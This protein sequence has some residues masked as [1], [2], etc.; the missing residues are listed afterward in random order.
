LSPLTPADGEAVVYGATAKECYSNDHHRSCR[1]AR[2]ARGSKHVRT[3]ACVPGCFDRTE[4][5]Q[6]PHARDNGEIDELKIT[7]FTLRMLIL[8]A[9]VVQGYQLSGGPDWLDSENYDIEAKMDSA[10]AEELGKLNIAQRNLQTLRML[11]SLLAD[12]FNLALHSE[13]EELPVYAL[14][15]A[16]DGPKFR[17]AIP[18]DTYPNGIT[19]LGGRPIGGG[20][21]SEPER[22]KLVG[23]GCPIAYL[24]DALS[25][26]DLGRTVRGSRATMISPC[27]GRQRRERAPRM[28]G[29]PNSTITVS[30][31]ILS[32]KTI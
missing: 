13:T 6:Q 4:Q 16:N 10:V 17:E 14:V 2:R 26:E 1:E 21:I 28:A 11:Q 15:I 8:K 25:Q 22:G 29:K 19:G 9:Y 7:N 20:A 24:V 30:F 3:R 5:I 12:R 27:S 18:G 23:Q 32:R 31:S